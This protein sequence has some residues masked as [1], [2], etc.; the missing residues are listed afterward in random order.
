MKVAILMPLATQ[1]GG[2]EQL[3]RLLMRSA[4]RGGEV[5]WQVVFLEDGPLQGEFE[6]AGIRTQVLPAGRLRQVGRY[7]ATVRR[8]AGL[9]QAHEVDLAFSWMAKAHLYGGPAAW[10]GGVPAAWYQHGLARSPGW[11]ERLVALVP[12]RGV[13]ACSDAAASVQRQ[14]WPARPTRTVHP[15]IELDRFDPA[16]LPSPAEAR[17]RLGLPAEGPLVGIV[18]RLQRWK[19][20]HVFIEALPLIRAAHPRAH[21]VVVGGAHALEPGYSDYVEGLTQ[22]AG[23][24]SPV[25]LAGFQEN[26]PLWMQAMDVVVH[27]SDHEPFGMVIVE[28]MALGKPVVAGA[29]GGPPE[30]ITDGKDGLLAPYG[31]AEAL[32]QQVLRFLDHPDLQRSAGEAARR[33]A[34]DFSPER[35]A[36]HFVDALRSLL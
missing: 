12:A 26:V 3:L 1:R 27:A 2:A 8:L 30:I 6:E 23:S 11:M 21:G 35:Y 31:D 9:L 28:A 29:S 14:R 4:P 25:T 24:A 36:E 32:A 34:Q 18:G 33:R 19:G 22:R 13:L 7:Q 5:S 10:W 17:R 15:C 20:I 16:T